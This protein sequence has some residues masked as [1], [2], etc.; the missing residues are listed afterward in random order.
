M[1][2]NLVDNILANDLRTVFNAVSIAR[3]A[4]HRYHT[5]ILITIFFGRLFMLVELPPRLYRYELSYMMGY[6]FMMQGFSSIEIN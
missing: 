3:K 1:A 5:V 2:E 6:T 4:V